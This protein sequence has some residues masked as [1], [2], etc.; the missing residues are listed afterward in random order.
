[1][2]YRPD[3][4]LS[5]WLIHTVLWEGVG[6]VLLLGAIIGYIAGYLLKIALSKKTIDE[7]SYVT[8]HWL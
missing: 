4:A 3:E 7:S 2:T 6:A 1:M 8:Y 5:Y